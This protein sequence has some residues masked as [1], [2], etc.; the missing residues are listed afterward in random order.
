MGKK[1]LS[2]LIIFLIL[3]GSVNI[4]FSQN[5]NLS[6]QEVEKLIEEVATK[7]AFPV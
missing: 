6:R 4:G 5:K 7:G 2:I 1:G 3:F